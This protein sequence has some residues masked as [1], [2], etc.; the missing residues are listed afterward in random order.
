MIDRIVVSQ[1]ICS[2]GNGSAF[3]FR[4]FWGTTAADGVYG[5]KAAHSEF[6]YLVAPIPRMRTR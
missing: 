3:V 6:K 2:V 1:I 5:Y 4:G